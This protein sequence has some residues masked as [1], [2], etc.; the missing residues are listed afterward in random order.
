MANNTQR[1]YHGF[2]LVEILIVVVILGIL[3]AIVIPQ[4]TNAGSTARTN[5][6]QTQ[7]QS[8]RTQLDVYRVQHN[9]AAPLP[10]N[11]WSVLTTWTDS[12]GNTTTTPDLINYP[13]GPYFR[14]AMVNALN[15][16]TGISSNASSTAEGWFYN[17]TGSGFLIY[18][19]DTNGN[20]ISTY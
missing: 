1:H 16:Q 19:R 12:L 6:L 15:N 17:A 10:A 5:T 8:L 11:F 9:D 13:Y 20:S 3:A 4:F 7:L 2:T 14:T 18:G